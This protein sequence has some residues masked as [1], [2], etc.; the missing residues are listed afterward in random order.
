[1][2]A[3]SGRQQAG[4]TPRSGGARALRST[5]RRAAY[6]T[7][8]RTD[9]WHLPQP[10][11]PGVTL[12]NALDAYYVD[13]R[14]KAAF[15]GVFREG[16]PLVAMGGGE[17][18]NPITVAQYALGLY[19]ELREGR[20]DPER[21]LRQADW[22]AGAQASDGSWVYTVPAGRLPSPWRSAMAQGEGISVLVR[23]ARLTG[24]AHYLAA[25]E[26]ALA[27]Y[28]VSCREGG[29]LC[30]LDGRPWYE[31]YASEA[32]EPPFTLNGFVVALFGLLD[33]WLATGSAPA[34]SLFDDGADTLAYALPR[35]DARGWSCY[36]LDEARVAGVRL[37]HMASPF[38][39]RWHA[40]LMEI[41]AGLLGRDEFGAWGRR[42]MR[43][44]RSPPRQVRAVASKALFRAL[45]PVESTSL[46]RPAGSS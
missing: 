4:G 21:F 33:L 22:L 3:T 27:P 30:R 37:R 6:A 14:G 17:Y 23:A 38:Y 20:G 25:A 28:H 18:H 44:F 13:F 10:P 1:M 46:S 7:G 5:L 2:T 15:P 31:E 19:Q 9:Y 24:E 42:W 12:E 34:R 35:F 45:R 29:V 41:M 32:T 8:L 39:Q 11:Y 36:D 26:R 16:V 43:A 40:E